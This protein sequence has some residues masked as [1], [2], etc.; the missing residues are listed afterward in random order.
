M[1]REERIFAVQR[2]RMHT[3][4]NSIVVDLDASIGEE[5]V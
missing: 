1:A 5:Q 2:D 3:T 4:L